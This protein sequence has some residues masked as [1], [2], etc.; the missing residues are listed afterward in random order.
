ML[1]D[2]ELQIEFTDIY[3]LSAPKYWTCS[4]II[5]NANTYIYIYNEVYV[6]SGVL[7]LMR[8]GFR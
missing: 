5:N 6:L 1:K 7:V 2:Y 4:A 3:N 8:Q